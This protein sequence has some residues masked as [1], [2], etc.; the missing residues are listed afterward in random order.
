MNPQVTIRLC[1]AAF[2]TLLPLH[3]ATAQGS[4][5]SCEPLE[6]IGNSTDPRDSAYNRCALERAPVLLASSPM[7]PQP[8]EDT[9]PG[10]RFYV[11]VNAD[12]RVDQRLTQIFSRTSDTTFFRHA[13]E[14]IRQWRFEPGIYRGAPVRS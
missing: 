4:R 12:G 6:P 1:F 9:Q 7:L 5:Q 14:T 13:M 10:G 2:V 8:L 11:I 3:L